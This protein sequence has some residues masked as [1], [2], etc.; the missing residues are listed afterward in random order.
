MAAI[1][2]PLSQTMK[3]T[4]RRSAYDRFIIPTAKNDNAIYSF[5]GRTSIVK[6]RKD[7]EVVS[8]Q[9][10]PNEAVMTRQSVNVIPKHGL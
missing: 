1:G 2:E 9:L 6:V 3:T 8:P 5:G 10:L 4:K 7:S